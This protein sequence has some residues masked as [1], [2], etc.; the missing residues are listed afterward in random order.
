MGKN[1]V[2]KE[3]PIGIYLKG[4]MVVGSPGQAVFD[5]PAG[6]AG[7]IS[8]P[9]PR[10]SNRV[11]VSC[12]HDTCFRE[13][14]TMFSVSASNQNRSLSAWRGGVRQRLA[15]VRTAVVER[16]GSAGTQPCRLHDWGN[17]F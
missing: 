11:A 1:S 16:A 6:R 13:S 14:R 8:R 7:S 17:H 4:A 12:F 3:P 9:W 2:G 15:L 10:A 5:R